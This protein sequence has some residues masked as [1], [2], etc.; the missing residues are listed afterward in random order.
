MHGA[1]YPHIINQNSM[2][3]TA[4]TCDSCEKKTENI[5][6]SKWLEIGSESNTLFINNYTHNRR[7]MQAEK[8]SIMHFC[9]SECVMTY[10]FL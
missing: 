8:I 9:S 2:K 4:Y 10:L 6:E 1:N 3:I 5:E 7:I